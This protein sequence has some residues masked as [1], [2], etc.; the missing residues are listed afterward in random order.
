MADAID[1]GACQLIGLG[2]T[3]VLEPSVPRDILL[4]PDLS[5]DEALALP[6]QIGGLWLMI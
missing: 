4:N 6:R 2:R 5:D 1:S 3:T